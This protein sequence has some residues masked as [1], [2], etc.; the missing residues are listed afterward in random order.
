MNL[1]NYLNYLNRA[2]GALNHCSRSFAGARTVRSLYSQ[3]RVQ[4]YK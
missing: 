1:L 3:K 2:A 4:R